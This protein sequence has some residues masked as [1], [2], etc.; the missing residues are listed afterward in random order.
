MGLFGRSDKE[1]SA[2]SA[3]GNNTFD[4]LV[5]GL[6]N[7]GKQYARTRHN[8]GE[9]VAALL[10][11]RHGGSLKTSRDHAL[12]DDVRIGS[13]RV[14]LAFPTTFMNESGKA[15]RDL[16]RRYGFNRGPIAERLIVVH[17]ELDLP[18]GTVRVKVGGG[19]GGHNGLRSI[20]ADLGTQDY[21]RVRIGV[22][23]PVNK[24]QGANHVLSKVPAAE[25]QTLDVGVQIA[26]DAVERIVADGAPAA[27]NAFNGQ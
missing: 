24:E 23:K 13:K 19:L 22:G 18:P 4:Y 1:S 8:V 26:A 5:V 3:S 16:S 14:V 17:D 11:S 20:T 2:K 15:V 9:E 12:V 25:R 6:G 21:I 10:A 7:P 27:M